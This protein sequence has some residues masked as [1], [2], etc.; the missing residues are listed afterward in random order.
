MRPADEGT[1]SNKKTI[2][3]ND[4]KSPWDGV[5]EFVKIRSKVPASLLRDDGS[6]PW[7][8]RMH[9]NDA[10][11][12][13]TRSQHVVPTGM[14]ATYLPQSKFRAFEMRQ[15]DH[16]PSASSLVAGQTAFVLARL[17]LP[18]VATDQSCYLLRDK[19]FP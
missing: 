15:R 8:Q 19:F 12:P 16:S 2:F 1:V 3:N 17:F 5:S 11:V 7:S 18:V 13:E 10:R 9:G 6:I 14:L 4:W